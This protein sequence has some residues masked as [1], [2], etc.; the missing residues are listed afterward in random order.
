MRREVHIEIA[1]DPELFPGESR[2]VCDEAEHDP[3]HR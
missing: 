2:I 3:R 1:A